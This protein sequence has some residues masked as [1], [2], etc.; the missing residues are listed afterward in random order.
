M[1]PPLTFAPCPLSWDYPNFFL[2]QEPC[3]IL[4]D[5]RK[6]NTSLKIQIISQ[7]ASLWP[8]CY[9]PVLIVTD[10]PLAVLIFTASPIHTSPLLPRPSVSLWLSFF[11]LKIVHAC[12]RVRVCTCIWRSY[13]WELLLCIIWNPGIKLGWWDLVARALTYWA[14]LLHLQSL[15]VTSLQHSRFPSGILIHPKFLLTLPSSSLCP[16]PH[17]TLLPLSLRPAFYLMHSI[18]FLTLHLSLFCSP[19]LVSFLVS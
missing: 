19:F 18:T 11:L 8:P 7:E 3:V 17:S 14:I 16:T 5:S 4:W 15:F 12:V 10:N 1:A 2:V 9:L 6:D 13:L